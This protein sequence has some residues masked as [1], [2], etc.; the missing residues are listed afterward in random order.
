MESK[1]D[2]KVYNKDFNEVIEYYESSIYGLSEEEAKI[3]LKK[4]GYNKL[5]EAKKTSF[6]KKIINQFKDF[7]T[8]ILIIA[9]ILSAI[10]SMNSNEPDRKSTR[11]NSS[12]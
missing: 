1:D 4:D 10:V 6:L 12:H 3:R 2:I 8:I 11:L 5:E 7:M 9:A